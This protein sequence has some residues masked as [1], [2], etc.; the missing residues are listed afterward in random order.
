MVNWLVCLETELLAASGRLVYYY[1]R[2]KHQLITALTTIHRYS[3]ATHTYL[4]RHPPAHV[5][6]GFAGRFWC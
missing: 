5:F 6:G 2:I 1:R 4:A 3:A